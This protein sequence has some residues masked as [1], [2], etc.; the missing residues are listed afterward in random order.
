MTDI[1]NYAEAIREV[2]AARKEVPG[3]RG[4]PFRK[5]RT[6]PGD[7]RPGIRRRCCED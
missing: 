2:T 7:F 4:Y 1:N 3:R 6:E 5:R